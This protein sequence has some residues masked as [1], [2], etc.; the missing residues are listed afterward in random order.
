MIAQ[1][2]GPQS[3]RSSSDRQGAAENVSLL[4]HVHL[5]FILYDLVDL[6]ARRSLVGLLVTHDG[7]DR[8]GL[9]GR[10]AGVGHEIHAGGFPR[11]GIE[12]GQHP[13]LEDDRPAT[14]NHVLQVRRGAR[15]A[16]HGHGRLGA[17][18]TVL[19]AG[20]A[21]GR[22]A[23]HVDR[24]LHRFRRTVGVSGRPRQ[25]NAEQAAIQKER[26]GAFLVLRES[27]AVRPIERGEDRIFAIGFP[28]ARQKARGRYAHPIG[29]LMTIHAGS[30]VGSQ[31]RK[32]GMTFGVHGPRRIEH[33]DA[34][35]P[36]CQRRR[37]PAG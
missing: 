11:F 26:M 29:R 18:E 15:A 9:Q 2:R 1:S 14:G 33:A 13:G 6:L 12:V 5:R 36:C 21:A 27:R 4:G 19:G 23:H 8:L 31:C 32:E 16:V 24:E 22:I 35:R 7:V 37:T 10:L 17:L 3:R 20:V 34:F 30:P 25:R 28:P